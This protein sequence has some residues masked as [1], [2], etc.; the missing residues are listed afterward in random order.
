MLPPLP[1]LPVMDGLFCTTT[2]AMTTLSWLTLSFVLLMRCLE[3]WALSHSTIR[4]TFDGLLFVMSGLPI[5]GR[6]S[7][8][9][10]FALSTPQLA[11][12]YV[13]HATHPVLL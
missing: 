6:G 1:A 11:V 3:T 2:A 9:G 7:L 4:P 5:P 12:H 10:S 8:T 13:L